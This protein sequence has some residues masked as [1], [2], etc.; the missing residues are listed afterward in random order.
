MNVSAG[1]FIN[2]LVMQPKVNIVTKL[3]CYNLFYYTVVFNAN[4][5]EVLLTKKFDL[6]L[7]YGVNSIEKVIDV[8]KN[9][10]TELPEDLLEYMPNKFYVF[11]ETTSSYSFSIYINIILTEYLNIDKVDRGSAIYKLKVWQH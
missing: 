2:D 1:I 9:L 4:K 3:T 7:P 11:E 8:Y 6:S 5:R 10:I